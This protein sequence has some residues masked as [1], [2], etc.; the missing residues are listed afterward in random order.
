MKTLR[1][2]TYKVCSHFLS[3]KKKIQS[4]E[5]FNPRVWEAEAGQPGLE[6]RVSSRASRATKRN[7][8]SENRQTNQ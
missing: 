2:D 6:Y 7:P 5:A 8:V 4:G 3:L 1:V